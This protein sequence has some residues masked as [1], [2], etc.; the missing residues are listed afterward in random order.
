MI[1][2]RLTD[3]ERRKLLHLVI[4]AVA[5]NHGDPVLTALVAK[6]SGTDTVIVAHRAYPSA[7][8]T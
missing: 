1:E 3:E 4:A 2:E 8:R 5:R 6:L 7:H